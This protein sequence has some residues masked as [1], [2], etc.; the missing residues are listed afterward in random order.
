MR[1]LVIDDDPDI[2]QFLKQA[3]ED[4][5]LTV[6]TAIDGTEGSY[7][8]RTRAY[9]AIV[10]DNILPRKNGRAVLKEIRSEGKATPVLVLSVQGEIDDKIGLLDI[11]A[12]DYLTK[13]FS[14]KEL[15][16]RLRA[17]ARRPPRTLA[18]VLKVDDL[19][20]DPAGHRVTRGE[21]EIYLTRKEFALAEYM[22]RNCGTIVSRGML[23]EHVWNDT[24]DAFSNTIEAHIRSLRQKIDAGD[25]NKLIQTVPGRGYK[26]DAYRM[27]LR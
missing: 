5:G 9:D 25:G 18:P 13:P 10:L 16:S 23:M 15:V 3:L 22:M 26:I 21:K 6:D 20:L 14:Y 4:E 27:I 19:T 12:D 1:I 24:V 8:A 7:L 17:L 2:R 11:G